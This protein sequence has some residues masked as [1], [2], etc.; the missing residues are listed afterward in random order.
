[1]T[2]ARHFIIGLR[3]VFQRHALKF[4]VAK[5]EERDEFYPLALHL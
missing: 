4:K 5:V 3:S 1:M 2:I